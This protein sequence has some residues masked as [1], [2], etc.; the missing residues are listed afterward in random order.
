MR[1][2]AIA[3]VLVLLFVGWAYAVSNDDCMSCHDESILEMGPEEYAEMV[4]PTPAGFVA[5]K[6]YNKKFGDISLAID[7]KR[8]NAS[9]HADLACTD[10]HQDITDLPHN[11]ELKAVDCSVCHD[12][13]GELYRQSIHYESIRKG[14]EL[15]ATCQDCHGTHYILPPSDPRSLT[16]PKNV[17]KMCARCHA[18]KEVKKL[19]GV[20]YPDA[21]SSYIGSVHHEELEKGNLKSATCSSCHNSHDTRSRGDPKSSIY[22]ANIAATCGKCHPEESK[23][24]AESVHG[25]SVAKGVWESPT[26]TDCH[27]GHRMMRVSDPESP[28]SHFRVSHE[29]CASCHSNEAYGRKYGMNAKVV[30]NYDRSPHG[31]AMGLGDPRAASCVSC[32]GAHDIRFE[33]DPKSSVHP[34]NMSKTCSKCHKGMATAL[35]K[36]KV[37]VEKSFVSPYI[38]GKVLAIVRIIY[39]ILITLVIGFMLL[40]NFI[41]YIRKVVAVLKKRAAAPVKYLRFSKS[42]RWQHLL[43]L[44][45]FSLLVISG[46][47]YTFKITIPNAPWFQELRAIVHRVAAVMFIIYCIWHLSWLLFT[48]RGRGFLVAMIPRP[49]DLGDLLWTIFYNLGLISVRPKYDRFNYVEKMEYFALIWGGVVMILTGFLLWFEAHFIRIFPIWVVDVANLIHLME[50]TLAALAI[51]VWHFYHAHINPDVSPMATH[52]ITGYL[53]EEEMEHEHPVELERIKARVAKGEKPEELI[54]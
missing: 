37:H 23:L 10:C 5:G 42:E 1:R 9:L 4:N 32:H 12:V 39:L 19:V 30:E 26:C 15:A 54:T 52:W 51:V 6:K 7:M 14:H 49:K 50:A 11:K 24:Y 18:Q 44:V 45:S 34:D 31:K 36:G 53:T 13:E 21:V 22:K 29:I 43:L 48:K 46:F 33:D 20:V 40:H 3:G 17:A 27:P 35:V 8:Y 2:V 28:N 25:L 38:G 47:M 16:N 41:D